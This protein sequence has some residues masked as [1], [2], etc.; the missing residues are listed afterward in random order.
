MILNGTTYHDETPVQLA[1][2]IEWIRDNGIRVKIQYGNTQTGENWGDMASGYIG[3]SNGRIKVPLFV[4]NR[5]S[6]GGDVVLDSHI[7]KI[8]YANKKQG[9]TIYQAKG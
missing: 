3:R 8:E 5:R 7:L 2:V 6:L 4:Y 1:Q 9:G